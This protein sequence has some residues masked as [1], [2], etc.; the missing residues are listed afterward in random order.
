MHDAKSR[1]RAPST[2]TPL[3]FCAATMPT[4][5]I[6][7]ELSEVGAS[8]SCTPKV[9]AGPKRLPD[10][11]KLESTWNC[12]NEQTLSASKISRD[13]C[14]LDSW[15]RHRGNNAA[16]GAAGIASLKGDLSHAGSGG[17]LSKGLSAA[18]AAG[19]TLADA[20]MAC[21]VRFARGDCRSGCACRSVR[22]SWPS[23]GG[24][25]RFPSACRRVDASQGKNWMAILLTVSTSRRIVEA[26]ILFC[27]E[28]PHEIECH[29]S[30]R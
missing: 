12:V 30:G 1:Q 19:G 17:K 9:Q 22:R 6:W 29:A 3:T 27:R 15:N 18:A 26:K 16:L 7:I 4:R 14:S 25:V 20:E 28:L 11:P 13:R 8:A 24:S 21:A 10:Q 23:S 2:G 5:W